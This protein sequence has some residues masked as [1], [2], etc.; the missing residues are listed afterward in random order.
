MNTVHVMCADT[1]SQI[2]PLEMQ[3]R[4][5]AMMQE[6]LESNSCLMEMHKNSWT[7]GDEVV[8]ATASA[9]ALMAMP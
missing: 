7:K 3:S 5:H 2:A 8:K 4:P 1:S 9:C 6:L